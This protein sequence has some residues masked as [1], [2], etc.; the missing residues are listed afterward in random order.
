MWN[1]CPVLFPRLR[2][3]VCDSTANIP[4]RAE[5]P[6]PHGIHATTN[7]PKNTAPPPIHWRMA[8]PWDTEQNIIHRGRHIQ[9]TADN[10]LPFFLSQG[11]AGN[12]CTNNFKMAGLVKF[13]GARR[14]A[15]EWSKVAPQ[16]GGFRKA[17]Q[18]QFRSSVAS[19]TLHP[20]DYTLPALCGSP[21]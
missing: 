20:K 19:D 16:R 9:G 15:K 10:I 2:V 14:E 3:R 7:M 13:E 18:R 11:P 17:S 21:Y 12:A 8:R 5:S 4:P 1:R 6:L